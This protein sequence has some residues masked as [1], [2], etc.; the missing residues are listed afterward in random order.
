MREV[1]GKK[2]GRERGREG[3]REARRK[4]EGREGENLFFVLLLP[5]TSLS[6]WSPFF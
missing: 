5:S 3:R 4:E 6:P 2:R 1:R